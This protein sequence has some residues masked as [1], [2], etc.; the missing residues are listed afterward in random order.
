MPEMSEKNLPLTIE[1]INLKNAD[2]IEQIKS[3]NPNYKKKSDFELKKEILEENWRLLYVA[4]TRAKNHLYIS[5]STKEQTRYGK[6]KDSEPSIVFEELLSDI[7]HFGG[8]SG[9]EPIKTT[10]AITH[11]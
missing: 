4:I 8:K 11:E 6:L 2:F 3:L 10:E 7:C 1:S 9:G 5:A